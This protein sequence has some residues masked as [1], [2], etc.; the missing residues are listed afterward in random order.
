MR[1]RN[2]ETPV[3]QAGET[4]RLEIPLDREKSQKDPAG[5]YKL[6]FFN[7]LKMALSRVRPL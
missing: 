3:P 2:K 5:V 1:F 6:F 4:A 7:Y